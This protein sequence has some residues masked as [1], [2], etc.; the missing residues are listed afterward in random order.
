MNQARI[1]SV[2]ELA[3]RNLMARWLV[4]AGVVGPMVYVAVFTLVGFLR[5]SSSPIHQAISD[6]GVG[7][8]AWLL[9]V[10]A[11]ITGL[12]LMG[13]AVGFA[14]SMQPVLSRG[15]RWSCATLRALHGLGLVLLSLETSEAPGGE[16]AAERASG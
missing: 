12:L 5:P 3:Q 4:L 14:L 16:Q 8:G 9:D 6:L 10:S 15:W 13:F 1:P 11:V 2:P 7:Q